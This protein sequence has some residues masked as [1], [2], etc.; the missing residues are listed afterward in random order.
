MLPKRGSLPGAVTSLCED[1]D[2]RIWIGTSSNGLYC[3]HSNALVAWP[4]VERLAGLRI[5]HLITDLD[6]NLW[7]TTSKGIALVEKPTLNRAFRS[8]SF[9][10]LRMI[11][12][13]T[14]PEVEN[15]GGPNAMRAR[16]GSLWFILQGQVI[17]VD[18]HK[19]RY[20]KT[21]PPVYIEAVSVNSTELD[22]FTETTALRGGETALVRLPANVHG[23]DIDFTAP[24]LTSPER[25]RFRYRLDSIDSD[26]IEGSS[27]KRRAHYGVIP[28]GKYRFQVAA[29]NPEGTWNKEGAVFAFIVPVPL[30]RESWVLALA[31]LALAGL[32]AWAARYLS[33][34]R[35]RLRLSNLERSEEMSRERMRLAQDMHDEIGSK[36]ARISF[37]SEVVK[38]EVKGFLRHAEVVDSLAKTARDLLQ[39]LDRMVWAVNPRNDSLESLASYLNRYASE[40]FQCTS[41]VCQLAIPSNLPVM[42][43]S[44]EIRHNIFLA[45]EECLANAMKH[46]GADLVTVAL[47]LTHRLLQISITDNGTGFDLGQDPGPPGMP[48]EEDRLGLSGLRRRMHAIGGS[49]EIESKP[50]QGTRI[51]LN[52]SLPHDHAN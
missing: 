46:S 37:L 32:A 20:P 26:W 19:W 21:V 34:R 47:T 11:E 9:P 16:D 52:L 27:I 3:L 35:L 48:A 2:R 17:R 36:L 8:G 10:D 29:A 39:S 4:A 1:S 45:F 42:P 6:D 43:L 13:L 51:K 23:L 25:T 14:V 5:Y 22:E 12:H 33:H 40:Y 44:A 15:S 7:L 24:C 41:I 49:C 31:L 38:T 30:W 28:S 18:P 50:G